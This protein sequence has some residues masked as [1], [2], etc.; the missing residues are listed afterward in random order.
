MFALR[1]LWLPIRGLWLTFIGLL[2]ALPVWIIAGIIYMD[3][4]LPKAT[5]WLLRQKTGFSCAFHESCVKP[6]KGVY[7]FKNI[8]LTNP[9]TYPSVDF[10][11]I[12]EVTVI[13][14]PT[15]WFGDY[16]RIDKL[17]I[18]LKQLAWTLKNVSEN[19]F[20]E[21]FGQILKQTG[22]KAQQNTEGE[23]PKANKPVRFF[24]KELVVK[25]EG[26]IAIRDYTIATPRT[27]DYLVNFNRTYTNV[28]HNLDN[29][30]VLIGADN[31]VEY[32]EVIQGIVREFRDNY[33][34]GAM[35]NTLLN[36]LRQFPSLSDFIR[37][38]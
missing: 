24:I 18:D 16:V 3:I 1:L 4:W 29:Q 34:F 33:G 19:N 14:S 20:E 7:T 12:K 5:E 38:L 17:V 27:R 13:S 26:T 6:T 22:G 30:K 15:K 11:N 21:F 10:A 32:T 9:A 36:S 23:A 8:V 31:Y 28:S 37:K 25:F 35:V 2:M